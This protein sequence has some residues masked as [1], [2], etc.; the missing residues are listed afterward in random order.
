MKS[1]LLFSVIFKCNYYIVFCI[2]V[3]HII[4]NADNLSL[5]MAMK[6]NH[7]N[8]FCTVEISRFIVNYEELRFYL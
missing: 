3:V 8:L 1:G 6:G 2:S 5:F 7:W 4:E